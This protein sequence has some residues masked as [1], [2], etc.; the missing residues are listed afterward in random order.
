[1]HTTADKIRALINNPDCQKE[2]VELMAA[3]LCYKLPELLDVL[4]WAEAVSICPAHE[5]V[6]LLRKALEKLDAPKEGVAWVASWIV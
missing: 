2:D 3:C 5:H 1:M 4:H 6:M